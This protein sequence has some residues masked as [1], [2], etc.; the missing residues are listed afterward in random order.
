MTEGNVV[1]TV[2]GSEEVVVE[3]VWVVV[4]VD[5]GR[6]DAEV[7]GEDGDSGGEVWIGVVGVE[8]VN[9]DGGSVRVVEIDVT[10]EDGG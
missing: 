2:V 10:V 5:T 4:E 3:G 8:V 6:A 1:E 9:E 7:V